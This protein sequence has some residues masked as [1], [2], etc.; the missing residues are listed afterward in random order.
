MGLLE[1]VYRPSEPKPDPRFLEY[2][3]DYFVGKYVLIGFDAYDPDWVV[4]TESMWVRVLQVAGPD[5]EEELVGV[6]VNVPTYN[7]EY[8]EGKELL[9]NRDEI[10]DI[11]P[12]EE[13]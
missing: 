11:Y 5:V 4:D 1:P 10:E 13:D 12:K 7:T 8:E 2:E 3:P 6:L 9:L